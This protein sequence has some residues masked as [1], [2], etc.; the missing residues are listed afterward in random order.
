MGFGGR[1]VGADR[2]S[3][4]SSG[5]CNAAKYSLMADPARRRATYDDLR[6]VPAHLV[7]E[8]LD[9]ELV[10]N[11]RPSPRHARAASSRSADILPKKLRDAVR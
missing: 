9:G 8:L 6:A 10:P 7:A 1:G 11:P 2:P 4:A 3:I 5:G